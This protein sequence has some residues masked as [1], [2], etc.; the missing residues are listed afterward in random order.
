MARSFENWQPEKKEK[1]VEDF[2]LQVTG[3]K[4]LKVVRGVGGQIRLIDN[5]HKFFAFS[6]LAQ[7]QGQKV[8]SLQVEMVEDYTSLDFSG[9]PVWSTGTMMEDLIAQNY[10]SILGKPKPS[11]RDLEDIPKQIDKLQNSEDRSIMG[12]VFSSFPV[13]LKGSDFSPMIQILLAYRMKSKG[14]SFENRQGTYSKENITRLRQMIIQNPDLV[15]FLMERISPSLSQDR[16]QNIRGM[17]L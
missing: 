10:I 13:P 9:S 1:R 8:F 7:T 16:V 11:Y 17:F 3:S 6:R 2:I 4:P 15:D 5:H 12:F 14:V